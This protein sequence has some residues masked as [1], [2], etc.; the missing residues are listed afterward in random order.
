[1]EASPQEQPEVIRFWKV[2]FEI[3][4]RLRDNAMKELSSYSEEARS[5]TFGQQKALKAISRA[6]QSGLGGLSLKELADQLE[7]TSGTVSTLVESLVQR[8]GVV[9]TPRP[10][11]RRTVR[12]RLSERGA[13]MMAEG[14]RCFNRQTE[15]FWRQLPEQERNILNNRLEEFLRRISDKRED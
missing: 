9:R 11:D 10:D 4:D 2:I 8:G 6:E 13:R 15:P 5:L 7:L 3:T 14:R 1:M 12:L